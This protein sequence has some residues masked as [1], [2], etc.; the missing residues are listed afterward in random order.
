MDLNIFDVLCS[1]VLLSSRMLNCQRGSAQLPHTLEQAVSGTR[2]IRLAGERQGRLILSQTAV[3]HLDN[4][5]SARVQ[6]P[7]SQTEQPQAEN[8]LEPS[9]VLGEARHHSWSRVRNL[10]VL[11]GLSR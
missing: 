9:Q 10:R 4:S 7:D 6:M 11:G 8:V 2:P 3:S 5:R 1:A